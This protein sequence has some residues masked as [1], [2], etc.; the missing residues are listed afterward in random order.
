MKQLVSIFCVALGLLQCAD[1]M[2]DTPK[3]ASNTS[4]IPPTYSRVSYGADRSQVMDV[5]LAP[6]KSP[7]PVVICI[8]GGSWEGGNRDGIQ[9]Y[10]LDSFLKAGISVVTIDY[11]YITPAIKAGVTPPVKGPLEDA[12][13]ALQFIR[14]KATDWNL[15][16]SRVGLMG[17]SAGGCS[18]LWLA[19]H[20]D[21]ADPQSPDPIAREST[22]VSCVGVWDAQSSL[23]PKQ[24]W[25][26]FKKP[27]YGAHAFGIVKD[28][29]GRLTSDMDTCLAERERIL[30][31][32]KEYSPIEQASADDPPIFLSYGGAPEPAG[33]PQLNSV[34]GAAFG[35]HLKERLNELG[36]ECHIAYPVAPEN[37]KAPHIQFLIQKLTSRPQVEAPAS[38]IKAPMPAL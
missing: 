38:G 21:M 6:S 23:D 7:T 3:S 10:G 32:I 37:P 1:S 29:D 35:I 25:E 12:M 36:V 20:A 8:H 17:G 4:V 14:S 24:L 13:R 18:S 19:M 16:K 27:T 11:R 2:A 28:K 5:W 9:Q 15:D 34:H 33:Q 26:W 31:W 30:P 22:R